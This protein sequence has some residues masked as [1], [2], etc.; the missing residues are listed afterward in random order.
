[1][2]PHKPTPS[3]VSLGT[4]APSLGAAGDVVYILA[5]QAS[6]VPGSRFLSTKK[7]DRPLVSRIVLRVAS[8]LAG[9]EDGFYK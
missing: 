6:G 4:Q 1:L 7:Q 3:K 8:L 9:N 2:N 5:L